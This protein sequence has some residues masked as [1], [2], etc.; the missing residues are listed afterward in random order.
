MT[1][2]T[3]TQ[4]LS[5][6]LLQFL[7]DEAAFLTMLERCAARV[8]EHPVGKSFTNDLIEDL[9]TIQQQVGVRNQQRATLQRQLSVELLKT[10]AAIRLSTVTAGPAVTQK[11]QTRRREILQKALSVKSSLRTVISQM[12]ESNAI[13]AAVLDAVLGAPV[14]RSR[15][16]SKGKPVQQISHVEGRRV[17]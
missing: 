17:A 4:Q 8:G 12:T 1:N 15:Y 7:D 9:T 5:T 6:E 2:S 10:P 14:D 16:D 3:I 11:I 13:V